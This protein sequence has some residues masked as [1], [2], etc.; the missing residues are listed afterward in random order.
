MRP[1]AVH[2]SAPVRVCDLGGW[3]DTWFAGHGTVLNVA[4]RPGAEVEA[5]VSGADG[6]VVLDVPDFGDRYAVPRDGPRPG[7]HPLLEACL[8]EIPP[9]PDV[10]CELTVS[11]AVPP[12]SGVGTSAAVAVGLLAVLDH[13]GDGTRGPQDL[14]AAAHRVE[15]ERLGLQSGIQD[16]L[17]AACGGIPSIEMHRYPEATVTPVGLGEGVWSELDRRLVVVFLGRAHAS[18]EVHERVIAR[19]AEE[20][21]GAPQLEALRSTAGRGRGAL[22]TGDLEAF[23]RAMIENTEAQ[24]GLHP[25]LVSAD[26]R[27]IIVI[28][29]EH[30]ASGWKV[31]GAGGEGGSMTVLAGPRDTAGRGLIRAVEEAG[32]GWAVLPVSLSA[33]GVQVWDVPAGPAT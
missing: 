26:A 31:N 3:T 30:G 7:R 19:L 18:S 20:G 17:A 21:E 5:V 2:G 33:P 25:E 16:Q 8:E 6:E 22:E 13:L 23:G 11:S 12:G 4:V 14:A 9:P 15:T 28:A 10:S 27:E 1:R 29:R 32:R 24:V